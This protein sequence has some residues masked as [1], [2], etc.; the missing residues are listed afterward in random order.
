MLAAYIERLG[1]PEEIRVG[2]LADPRPGPTDVL[3]EVQATT[4][5]PVDTFVRSGRFRTPV[6][7]PFVIGRDLVGRVVETGP[8]A[9]GFAAGDP[10][11]GNS[12]G[13]EG[14]QG[15]AAERAVVAAD[16]L[17]RL[18]ERVDPYE[19]VA[20]VHPAATAH[21]ALF[22]HGGLRVG[23]TVLVAGAAGNV[24]SALVTLAV[25]A[26]ARVLA[27]AAPRDAG[28]CRSLGATAAFDYADPD[29]TSR[30][31]KAA[32]DGVDL[33]LDTSG[34]NDLTAAVEVLAHR[35][36]IVL[37]AGATTAPVLPAGRL[38][39]KDGS[40]RG[41]VI[42]HATSAELAAAAVAI[43][44]LLPAGRLRPRAREVRPL[45]AAAEAHRGLEAGELSGKR[46]VLSIRSKSNN[47]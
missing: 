36:R 16:R 28:Y 33:H 30:L 12:L 18:P 41:F 15:A 24:G 44:R 46:V 3:V 17:Y 40:V 34:G 23:E 11:W 2:E 25:E 26:G 32:P 6:P 29:L 27:T 39:L 20:V 35:G 19:A 13:H 31:R 47:S 45:S 42:S 10:V 8:G 9:H 4:V 7:F 21:L 5:N 37:L 22:T 1:T 14:R 38:Y 43:N